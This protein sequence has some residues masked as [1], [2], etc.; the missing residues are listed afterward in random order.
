[1]NAKI[2]RI[3]APLI[4]LL[5]ATSVH[6]EYRCEAPR[7]SIDRRACEAAKQGPD[8]LRQFVQRMR[9]IESLDMNE[10]VN[11]ATVLAWEQRA[12]AAK[13]AANQR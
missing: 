12:A 4:A 10:Y 3:A 9:P 6:A 7:S 11:E 2:L 5:A 1:M 13:L 8:A